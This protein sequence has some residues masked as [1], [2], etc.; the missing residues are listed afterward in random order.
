MEEDKSLNLLEPKPVLKNHSEPKK[1]KFW[2]LFIFLVIILSI[3]TVVCRAYTLNEWPNQ[4]SQYDLKTLK[5]KG[6]GVLETVKNF[7]FHS[8]NVLD[9]QR[10]DRIN[11]LMLGIGGSGHDGPYLSDTN[12]ILSIKPS[13]KEV[14]MISIPRDL[15][16]NI[17]DQGVR[18]INA[19][20]AFG[21]SMEQGGG[22]EYA[23]QIFSKN[24]GIDI[25]YYVRVDFAAFQE[26]IDEIGGVTVNVPR[27]FV[28]YQFP[29]PNFSYRTVSFE[30]GNKTLNGQQALDFAR[31]RHGNN[32]EGSDFARSHR[33]QLIMNSLKE[34]MLSIGTYTNPIRVQQILNSL[35]SHILTNLNFGQIMYLANLAKESSSKIKMLV[36]DNSND[37]LLKSYIADS[38][39]YMLAPVSGNFN[40][41]NQA[42]NNVFSADNSR[43]TK[44]APDLSEQNK[45]VFST[46]KIQVLNGTWRAGL[47]AKYDDEMS[48]QGLS[49]LPPANSPKRPI[50]YTVIYV[51]N[52][53]VPNEILLAVK[54]AINAEATTNLPDWLKQDT[55]HLNDT[56]TYYTDQNLKFNPEADILIVLGTDLSDKNNN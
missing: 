26:I 43:L 39:A 19:V 33:Q 1:I 24:F 52:P 48:R 42:I 41:I 16:V 12:I 49:T 23:R 54:K 18:K 29:G 51:L 36:I 50:D 38:G 6:S 40:D 5:P 20:D 3:I 25:Q 4:A 13:T 46:G 47:A 14:A 21:E 53:K 7:I 9:G 45:P 37:G 8:D 55:S 17:P 22:G 11:I 28:D 32:G 27:T 34:K 10:E 30:A 2:P 35:N 31:S 15:G 44:T 56:S